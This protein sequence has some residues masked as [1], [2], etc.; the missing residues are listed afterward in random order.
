MLSKCLAETCSKLYIIEYIVVLRL[1][2]VFV[3]ATTQRGGCYQ[4]HNGVAAI[5]NTTGWLLSTTQR[6]GC[7]QQNKVPFILSLN[8]A[9][10][11]RLYMR[12][13]A[14]TLLQPNRT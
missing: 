6:G 4:Q 3:S 9:A 13:A 1:N 12:A 5:N 10:I 8:I 11:T 2:D 14:Q 7:Y